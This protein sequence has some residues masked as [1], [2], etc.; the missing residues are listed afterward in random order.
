MITT[1][2]ELKKME[3][4]RE[5]L[6]IADSNILDD[7]IAYIREMKNV[8]QQSPHYY[9]AKGIQ[10][11]QV[12]EP[13]ENTYPSGKGKVVSP[14]GYTTGDVFEKRVGERITKFYQENGLL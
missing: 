11:Q 3:I 4:F 7:T 12:A 13:L 2:L 1:E 9:I 6:D 14:E 5:I 10:R 8:R